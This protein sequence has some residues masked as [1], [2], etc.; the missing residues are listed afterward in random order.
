M[1][2]IFLFIFPPF[3]KTESCSDSVFSWFLKEW[4]RQ[5]DSPERDD[6][7]TG[8]SNLL[9]ARICLFFTDHCLAAYFAA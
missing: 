6:K 5:K 8:S 9:A 3:E 2:V 4:Q 1:V 7:K